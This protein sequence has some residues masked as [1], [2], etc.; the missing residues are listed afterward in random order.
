MF[1]N[2][3][4]RISC[5]LWDKVVKYGRAGETTDDDKKAHALLHLGYVRLHTHTHT[6][7]VSLRLFNTYCLSTTL[8]TQTRLC[9]V[10]RSL[11]VLFLFHSLHSI[12]RCVY[13]QYFIFWRYG[14][15]CRFP[16]VHGDRCC[17]TVSVLTSESQP[18]ELK[19]RFVTA[20]L[21]VVCFWYDVPRLHREKC[22]SLISRQCLLREHV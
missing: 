9:Y 11:P 21:H 10:I 20:F 19:Q 3:S 7:S 2:I 4:P 18:L 22:P 12:Q 15:H 16:S 13:A 14:D 17:C 5:P 1:N 6:F 8:V